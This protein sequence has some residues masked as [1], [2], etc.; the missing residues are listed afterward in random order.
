MKHF[1]KSICSLILIASFSL[2]LFAQK[3]DGKY[4]AFEALYY[5]CYDN[6]DKTESDYIPLFQ[7]AEAEANNIADNFEK[8]VRLAWTGYIEACVYSSLE[9]LDKMEQVCDEAEVVAKKAMDMQETEDS[10]LV[11]VNCIGLNC[12]VKPL[13]YLMANGVNVNPLAKKVIKLNPKNGRA[14]FLRDSQD[15]YAPAPFNNMKKGFQE[16]KAILEDDTLEMSDQ[17]RFDT[18]CAAAFALIKLKK[19]DEAKTYLQAAGRI[20]PNN[21]TYVKTMALLE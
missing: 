6:L 15:I 8:T 13:S 7:A 1:S 10:I 9:D 16:M 20:F 19:T 14:V 12:L 4:P 3:I 5:A 17:V 2:P 11:Y 21:I 18:Y